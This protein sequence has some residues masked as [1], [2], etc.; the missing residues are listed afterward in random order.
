MLE[1]ARWKYVLVAAFWRWRCC[2]PC[3]TCSATTT[4]CRSRAKTAAPSTAA[5]LATIESTLKGAGVE[6]S[7]VG[8]RRRQRHRCGS[9]PASRSSRA[10]TSSRTRRP[11]S[12]K[13]YVNAMMYASRAPRWIQALGLRAMPLGLDL[14]GG[15]YLLYQV[16]VDGAVESLL[17]TYDQDFRRALR[18]ENIA[19]HRH[20]HAHG[21]CGRPQRPARAAARGRR[22]RSGARGSQEGAARSRLPRCRRRRGRRGRLRDDRTAGAR[23]PRLRHHLEHHHAAQSR[24]RARRVRAH[25][26]AP[27]PRSHRGA[28][29]RR[30]ELRRGEGH[31]RQGRHAR[32][33]AG[34]LPA[35]HRER[36]CALGRQA[37]QG[38]R[39]VARCC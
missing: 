31:P 3:L 33:P 8:A 17:N 16:D 13:D 37:L 10:A 24:Q 29:A 19:V 38:S 2:S 18:T 11:A 20:Q 32:I 6:F 23:A 7:S 22:P 12:A 21:R 25:R 5:Q 9:R 14:R 36:P 34:R 27:G 28:A 1:Y 26:A 4:R 39:T 35:T 30:A 15:L